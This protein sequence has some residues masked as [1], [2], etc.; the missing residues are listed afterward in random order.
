MKILIT[1]ATGLVG[2]KLGRKLAGE[3]HELIVVS[4]DALK[5]EKK[6][7]F[8]ARILEGDLSQAPLLINEKIDIVVHLMGESVA[9]GRW[10][11]RQKK[12]IM[13]SRVEGTKNLIASLT[14][15]PKMILSASAIGIYGDQK[16]Q[17]V[18]EESAAG[19]DF[20]AQ[21]CI[22]WERELFRAS[23]KFASQTQLACLRLGVVLARNGGA[24]EKI[25]VPFR[26]GMGG[27]V[28]SGSQYMSWIHIDD[29]V[30]LFTFAIQNNFSGCFNAVSSQPVTNREFSKLLAQ[31]LGRVL[32]PRVPALVLQLML[33]EMSQVVL[34]SQRVSNE[35]ILL[36]NFKFKFNDLKSALND[37]VLPLR[38]SVEVLESAQFIPKKK[39]EIFEYFSEA[40]NLEE[41]TPQILQF[42]IQ[43]MSSAKIHQGTLIDYR[44]KIHGVPVGWR[45]LIAE[46]IPNEK[47]V[48]TQLKGPYQMWH[49]THTFEDL[50]GGTLM[51]D[52]VR[53]KLPLGYLGW[54]FGGFF[55]RS[56]VLK[57]FSYRREMIFKKFVKAQ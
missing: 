7:E 42:Q 14:H 16:D 50:A 24:L 2:Q 52:Y 11:D 36:Q 54:L 21:V 17:I 10:T 15:A 18:N 33:G 56:D 13:N 23:D 43:K 6:L 40:K 8:P 12:S 55:V 46:W 29:L 37:L 41:L 49:H 48:D 51:L 26:I 27:P 47:F 30:E 20:L 9:S 45:T 4:R 34:A 28:G 35:K 19:K 25:L 32:M 57:I 31:V 39:A 22:A 44:L 53:F 1:G 5:A 3:G 38:N